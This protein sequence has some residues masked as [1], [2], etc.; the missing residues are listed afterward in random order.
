MQHHRTASREGFRFHVNVQL[1]NAKFLSSSCGSSLGSPRAFPRSSLPHMPVFSSSIHTP[2]WEILHCSGSRLGAV[3]KPA[4]PSSIQEFHLHYSGQK[5]N[6]PI[7]WRETQ[8]VSLFQVTQGV[9]KC[10][11]AIQNCLPTIAPKPQGMT[12][13]RGGSPQRGNI[14]FP[15]GKP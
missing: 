10:K 1:Y 14:L 12:E 13:V 15:K 4:Y 8:S 6:L 7:T 3:G 9:Q 2:L 5:T 11:T